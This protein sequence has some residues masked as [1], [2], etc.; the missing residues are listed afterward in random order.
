[1][2][3]YDFVGLENIEFQAG[4]DL[5]R[6]APEDV[7][8]AHAIEVREIGATTCLTCRGIEPAAV[9]RRVVGLGVG[10]ATNESELESV[11]AYMNGLGSRYAIPVAPQS[12]PSTLPSWLGKRGFTPGYAWMKFCRPCDSR[13]RPRAERRVRASGGRGVRTVRGGRAM[14]RRTG[15]KGELDLRDGVRR[16]Q[17][18]R[19][20]RGIRK[21]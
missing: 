17:S 16:C 13:R 20:R 3:S 12:Q 11:L 10:R 8:R 7:R 18:C 6:A 14:G 19:C 21:R 1:V 5:Y 2:A 9:F 15:R 4:I